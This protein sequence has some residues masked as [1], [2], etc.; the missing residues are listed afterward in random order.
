MSPVLS[1]LRQGARRA[2]CAQGW[3]LARM[4]LTGCSSQKAIRSCHPTP[5]TELLA[6]AS[7]VTPA[8]HHPS[9]AANS[10]P[11]WLSTCVWSGVAGADDS[12]M[13]SA[14][15]DEVAKQCT[16]EDS[17]HAVWTGAAS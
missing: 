9:L 15:R 3:W 16:R 17:L 13:L 11:D 10:L 5:F 4:E 2:D 8:R 12:P 6:S 1:G 14:L 7:S